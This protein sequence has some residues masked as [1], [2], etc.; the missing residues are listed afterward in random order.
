MDYEETRE[1]LFAVGLEDPWKVYGVT[2][3]SP[4][5]PRRWTNVMGADYD[6]MMSLGK[7]RANPYPTRRRTHHALSRHAFMLPTNEHELARH[8]ITAAVIATFHEVS[9]QVSGGGKIGLNPHPEEKIG[10][11][12][13]N[14]MW[15]WQHDTVFAFVN[16]YAHRYPPT[17]T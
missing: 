5:D 4:T 8:L 15:R 1:R 17:S 7:N 16:A 6:I 10:G 9:E 14:E 12:S 2:P 3:A 13:Q 11:P